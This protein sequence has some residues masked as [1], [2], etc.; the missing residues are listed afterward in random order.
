MQIKSL[1]KDYDKMKS[2]LDESK[3][4]NTQLQQKVEGLKEAK[5]DFEQKLNSLNLKYIELEQKHTRAVNNHKEVV[6]EIEKTFADKEMKIVLEN[7]NKVQ[8]LESQLE[9]SQKEYYEYKLEHTGSNGQLKH[10]N[11]LLLSKLEE[12]SSNEKEY[13]EKLATLQA[14]YDSKVETLTSSQRQTE[15]VW[16]DKYTNVSRELD[17]TIEKLKYSEAQVAQMDKIESENESLKLKVADLTSGL[18]EK[19]KLVQ[20]QKNMIAKQAGE[21]EDLEL[22]LEKQEKLY[23]VEIND[24]NTKIE[25]LEDMVEKYKKVME[26]VDLNIKQIIQHKLP[27]EFSLKLMAVEKKLKRERDTKEKL[28]DDYRKLKREFMEKESQWKRQIITAKN[29]E[30]NDGKLKVSTSIPIYTD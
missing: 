20:N 26:K 10:E 18:N 27:Q 16:R 19:L 22:E 13:K 7:L 1:T 6:L 17:K 30:L 24:R 25:H 3:N 5:L 12:V 11:A 21:R 29:Q 4:L 14:L 23:E 28:Q 15:D 2:E 9:K 8:D